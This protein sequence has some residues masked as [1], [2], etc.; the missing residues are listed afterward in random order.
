MFPSS[1]SQLQPAWLSCCDVMYLDPGLNIMLPFLCSILAIN[2]NENRKKENSLSKF[3]ICLFHEPL[4]I[5]RKVHI[6]YVL[7]RVS[8]NLFYMEC[9]HLPFKTNFFFNLA[10]VLVQPAI[11]FFHQI[12]FYRIGCTVQLKFRLYIITF[13]CQ[14]FVRYQDLVSRFLILYLSS[15]KCL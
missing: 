14:W 10:L 9:P 3:N 2:Y 4:K 7:K 5:W 1:S 15:G 6:L 8:I 11:H 13:H 12:R